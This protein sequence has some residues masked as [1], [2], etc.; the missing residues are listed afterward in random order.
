MRGTD[1]C[2]PTADRGSGSLRRGRV[3][4]RIMLRTLRFGHLFLS[5]C[6]IV[7]A[8]LSGETKDSEGCVLVLDAVAIIDDLSVFGRA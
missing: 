2:W 7:F 1:E 6:N 5:H 4:G 8:L 3:M